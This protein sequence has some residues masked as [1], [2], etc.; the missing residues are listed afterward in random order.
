MTSNS[1]VGKDWYLANFEKFEKSLNG[2]SQ[3]TLH[4]I[5]RQAIGR[6]SELGFP[7][8][9]NEEW[10]YTDVS[11]ITKFQ[12]KP[13]LH[14]SA[15]G[16]SRK[17]IEGFRLGVQN[18]HLLVCI[19]GH[20]SRDLSSIGRLPGGVRA[21]GLADGI[22]GKESSVDQY[23]ARHAKFEHDAFTAL[24]T[25]FMR[26]GAF[27]YV[28]EGVMVDIPIHIIFVSTNQDSEF[29]SYPRSLVVAG[30]SS[31]VAFI[32]SHV[33][34]TEKPYLTNAVTEIV[35]GENAVVEH[36]K[37][38]LESSNAFHVS[39]THIYQQRS[40][41]FASNAITFGGR[42]VRNNVIAVLDGEGAEATLNGLYL[43]TGNQVIDN[44]TTI[45]HARPHC[46]SHELYKGILAGRS[47][48]VF[49]GKIFVRK[50]A[51]KTDAKQTN[52]NLVLSDEASINTKP[53]LEIFAD[54]VKCTH[55]AT[56][57]QLD[58]EAIFYL[59]SRGVRPEKARDILIYAFASDV[60]D[61]I[62][63]QEMR[64]KL[65]AMLH[66]RLEQSRAFQNK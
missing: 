50:E 59:R 52:K 66:D 39:T 40:S 10:K 21:S 9:R 12:F 46:P 8:T 37:V 2:E 5:R 48:G 49:S 47:K 16:V 15:D 58:D 31:Q 23:L 60:V 54:D 44:H 6:F 30:K 42:L 43:G 57:G 61:R 7:T 25:A 53:Q 33:S 20:F 38:Q 56:I 64:D 13:V 4:S 3:S 32:E 41:N 14:Y 62:R 34:L 51:Q 65:Q 19:N 55:G 24:S 18:S 63:I 22:R 1:L 27:V 29:V 17:D 11:P 35:L 28:P 36:D 45:D 26:D